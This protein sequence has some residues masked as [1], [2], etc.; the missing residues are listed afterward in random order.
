MQVNIGITGT[1]SLI[2][3][4][5]IKSIRDSEFVKHYRLVGLDYFKNTVGSFW[6]EENYLLPDILK[7]DVT[8]QDWLNVLIQVIK[9]EELKMLFIG[10]DFE[11][12]ILAK[13][14]NAILEETGCYVIVSDDAVIEV[15]NDKYLT[16]KFLKE[17]GLNYPETF[18]PEEVDPATLKYPLI[19]KPRVGAR[20]VG[21]YK[22]SSPEELKEKLPK[23]DGPILQELVGNDNT[24]YTCGIIYVGGELKAQI[25]LRRTLK[26]GNTAVSEYKEDFP[27]ALTEYVKQIAMCLKPFG[28]CNLQLR[29]DDN[30]V[31]KLFEIN[32]RHSGTT[33]MRT[34]FGYNEVIFLLK[35]LLE[36][37]ELEFKLKEGKAL[38]FYEERLV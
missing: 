24:E 3:Q 10:V 37:I 2:G 25:A 11:L 32:P 19:I 5:I 9:D 23:V 1:G 16:Y 14:K 12:P 29:M 31:P 35:Y 28:S 4:G 22:I 21:V 33:Y 30:G 15:G 34:L 20:S 27:E 36:D 17:N 38:R 6:C 8:N 26:E 13:V 18:L 7:S